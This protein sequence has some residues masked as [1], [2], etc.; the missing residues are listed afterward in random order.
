MRNARHRTICA[1][2]IAGASSLAQTSRAD[3]L[4]PGDPHELAALGFTGIVWLILLAASL[5]GLHLL[6]RSHDV[7][8]PP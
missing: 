7:L 6:R 3:E 1:L 5:A 2:L 8:P 4:I